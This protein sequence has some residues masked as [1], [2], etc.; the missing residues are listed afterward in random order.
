MWGARFG[1][2]FGPVVKTDYL[3]EMNSPMFETALRL[4]EVLQAPPARPSDNIGIKIK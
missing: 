1:R 2:G 3:K 4:S